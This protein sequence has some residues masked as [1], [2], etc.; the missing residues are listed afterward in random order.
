MVVQNKHR[1]NMIN[2]ICKSHVYVVTDSIL[3]G[4]TSLCR[5]DAVFSHLANSL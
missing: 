1:Y 4:F 2:T 5:D 3:M